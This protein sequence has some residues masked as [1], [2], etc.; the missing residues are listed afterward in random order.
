MKTKLL[1]V[2]AGSRA[3]GTNTEFSD[4][5]IRG[6][7]AND[8]H[9]FL[10]LSKPRDEVT[11]PGED[12]KYFSLHKFL[13]LYTKGNPNVVELLWTRD[14]DRLFT[15]VK[16]MPILGLRQALLCRNVIDSFGGYAKSRMMKIK[17]KQDIGGEVD[18][19]DLMHLCRLSRMGVEL[20]GS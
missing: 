15:D 10:M 6:V 7:F 1:K 4:E 17:E 14:E 2:M 8:V 20:I 11:G 13:H 16:F 12:E 18:Y 19:K 5:D 3:Y 9:E